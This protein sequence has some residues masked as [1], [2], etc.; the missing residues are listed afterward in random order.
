MYA[1]DP[2]ILMRWRGGLDLVHS[3]YGEKLDLD[4]VANKLEMKVEALIASAQKL[5][6][7]PLVRRIKQA[8]SKI[9]QLALSEYPLCSGVSGGKIT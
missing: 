3:S 6:G 5:F 2:I 9:V 8:L 7:S 4:G 1:F